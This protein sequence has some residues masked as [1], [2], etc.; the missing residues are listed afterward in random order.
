MTQDWLLFPY[1]NLVLSGSQTAD[2][3]LKSLAEIVSILSTLLHRLPKT[4]RRID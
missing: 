2:Y 3:I 1:S 4:E